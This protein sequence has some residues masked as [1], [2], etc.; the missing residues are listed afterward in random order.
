MDINGVPVTNSQESLKQFRASSL[1]IKLTFKRIEE[2]D[3]KNIDLKT[4]HALK[5][6]VKKE[7]TEKQKALEEFYEKKNQTQRNFC[8]NLGSFLSKKKELWEDCRKA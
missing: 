4:F 2:V 3:L 1:P 5:E 7:K 8:T 6:N